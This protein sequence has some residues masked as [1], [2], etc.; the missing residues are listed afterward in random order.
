MPTVIFFSV[1]Q[2]EQHRLVL[3][4]DGLTVTYLTQSTSPLFSS[5]LETFTVEQARERFPQY[6]SVIDEVL[7]NR[8][9]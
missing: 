1:G 6:A 2:G 9:Y 8:T 5:A 4:E 3:E 7:A